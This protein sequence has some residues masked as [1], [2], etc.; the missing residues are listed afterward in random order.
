M[1]DLTS[2]TDLTFFTNEE[3][4]TLLE[5]FK[6]TLKHVDK[7]DVLVGYFRIS[8]FYKLYKELENVNKIR[9]LNGLDVDQKTFEAIDEAKN[10]KLNFESSTKIKEKSS[11]NIQEEADN[12]EDNYDIYVGYQKFIEFIKNGK[13]E[14]KQHPSRKVHA[15]VYISRYKPPTSAVTHGQVITGSSNFSISGLKGNYEFNVKLDRKSDVDFALKKFEELWDESEDIKNIALD[16][17]INKTWLNNKITPYELYLKTLF[18]YFYEDLNLDKE[19][20]FKVPGSILKLEYQK[21][22]VVSA[23]KILAA[24]GGLFLSDVVGLGK[25]YICGLLANQPNIKAER[26]LVICSPQLIKYWE[27][28][29]ENFEVPHI[30]VFS[31]GNLKAIKDY[32]LID[33]V[34][35]IFIDEAHRFRN[36]DTETYSE[37]YKICFG[38]KIILI[39][40][41]PLNNKFLDIL[42]QILLFQ[43]A[44]KSSIPAIKNLRSFFNKLQNEVDHKNN[45]YDMKQQF[46][47]DGSQEIR[48]KVLKHI[49]IRRTRK[50]V[51]ETFGEDLKKQK[52]EFPKVQEPREIPYEFDDEINKI[53]DKTIDLLRNDF[54]IAIYLS[55]KYLKKG[56]T[57][58]E[59]QRQLNLAGFMKTLIIKRL[60]SSFY[61]FKETI[62][63]FIEKHENFINMFNKGKIYISK[64][65]NVYDLIDSDDD[66]KTIELIHDLKEKGNLEEFKSTDFK[67]KFIEDLQSDLEMF[68]QIDDLWKNVDKDPKIDKFHYKLKNDADL[69]KKII[70]FTESYDTGE[71]LLKNISDEYKNQT[72]FYSGRGGFLKEDKIKR[73]STKASL[74]IINENFNADNKNKS[75]QIKILICT[76][77]LAEGMNLHR[78]NV[79]LNYDLPWNPTKVIQR[80]GRINRVGTNFSKL[81]IYNFF[82]TVKSDEIIEQRQNII[83]KLQAFSNCLGNDTKHL[84]ENEQL[85]SFQLFGDTLYK[86]LKDKKIYD[87]EDEGGISEHKY[88]IVIRNIRDKNL[89]LFNKLQNDIPKKAR[90]SRIF[91][92]KKSLLSFFRKGKLK[93]FIIATNEKVQ[94][95]TFNEAINYLEC[96]P[97]EKK[98]VIPKIFFDLLDKN[99]KL[100]KDILE[101]SETETYKGKTRTNEAY[102][103]KTLNSVKNSKEFKDDDKIV[104]TKILKSF[105]HGIIDRMTIKKIKKEIEREADPIKVLNHFKKNIPEKYFSVETLTDKNL[106]RA[107]SEIILSEFFL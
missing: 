33:E 107:K 7:F 64:K 62:K 52:V 76:D 41:T 6:Q 32:H 82:P 74:D 85:S 84:S 34:K 57:E 36:E 27:E 54:Q 93:K 16:T 95:I 4:E 97:N 92:N 89:E 81:Y 2:N 49:M 21:Q 78:S 15:K 11:K 19:T 22:A 38:K 79:I 35:Y 69:K 59:K 8:G 72:F 12:E 9:I 98:E 56:K 75:D 73:K 3:G 86:K 1:N 24:Y 31:A 68:R 96:K 66:E 88:L 67:D 70:I 13:L 46:I 18:E 83:S 44:N 39:S 23:T 47:E 77:I 20:D 25:T 105:E 55:F 100:F 101:K 58:F 65:V 61:A 94:E 104:L 45:T 28:T 26:K 106:D 60:E 90:S 99:K 87:D 43:K 10:Y 17:L 14:L 29:M 63:R 102:L 51:E 103:I 80:L 48:E 40:A 53:F 71:Y 50:E 5:R 91:K 30:K 42:S 37:L